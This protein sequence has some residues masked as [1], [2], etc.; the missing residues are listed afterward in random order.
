VVKIFY[1]LIFVYKLLSHGHL[2]SWHHNPRWQ[3]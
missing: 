3:N 1:Y 2:N